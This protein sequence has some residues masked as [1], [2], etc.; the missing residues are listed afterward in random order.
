M[1]QIDNLRAQTQNFFKQRQGVQPASHFAAQEATLRQA[2]P[3]GE[4]H[5]AIAPSKLRFSTFDKRQMDQAMDLV[6]RY[7]AI[8]MSK[9]DDAG[10][11]AVLQEV[12]KDATTT[13]FVV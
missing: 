10:L 7:M 8:A 4:A 11:E 1:A 6:D 13:D 12:Q 5:P 9:S 2:A 3:A